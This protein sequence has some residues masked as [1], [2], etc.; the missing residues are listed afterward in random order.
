[1]TNEYTIHLDAFV[2]EAAL[3]EA[4]EGDIELEL[5][6]STGETV[7]VVIERGE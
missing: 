6:S 7:F 1:M 5:E 2:L 4:Q 3:Q